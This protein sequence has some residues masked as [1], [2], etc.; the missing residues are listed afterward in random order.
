LDGQGRLVD[1]LGRDEFE[2]E[3]EVALGD[4][5]EFLG[6][7]KDKDKDDVVQNLNLKPTWLL[8][9]FT[10]WGA[11]AAILKKNYDMSTTPA[12]PQVGPG[13]PR[14]QS[15]VLPPSPT[16]LGLWARKQIKASY[17]VFHPCSTH[18]HLYFF[19]PNWDSSPAPYI[20][21]AQVYSRHSVTPHPVVIPP[22][23]QN[24]P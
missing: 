9:F 4:P 21:Y 3:E 24:V 11:S 12:T 22:Q 10:R 18:P 17:L 19:T 1:S 14:A 23:P 13:T 20:I 2:V 16:P 7:F 5:G 8:R 6:G 15:P